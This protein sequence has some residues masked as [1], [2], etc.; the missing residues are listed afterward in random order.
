MTHTSQITNCAPDGAGISAGKITIAGRDQGREPPGAARYRGE[1]MTAELDE[2]HRTP[3]LPGSSETN[4]EHYIRGHARLGRY[5]GERHGVPATRAGQGV[6]SAVAAWF[7]QQGYQVVRS[8]PGGTP[9]DLLA[10]SPEELV[11]VLIRQTRRRPPSL[12]AIADQYREEMQTLHGLPAPQG[13][14]SSYQFWLSVSCHG[15]RVFDVMK[16]G[17]REITRE[18]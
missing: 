18:I 17:I 13:F 8:R 12:H 7:R 14:H 16:G 9:P 10:W 5:A 11:M 1:P 2:E 3:A 15:W 4:G 6:A